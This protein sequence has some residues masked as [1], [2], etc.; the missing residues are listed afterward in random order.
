MN[1]LTVIVIAVFIVFIIIGYARGLLRSVFKLVLA[2]LALVLA[3]FLTPMVAKLI[4]DYTPIDNYINDKVYEGVENIAR[5]K[6]EKELIEEFGEVKDELV[7]SLTAAAL[8]L[9]PSRNQ[10]INIIQQLKLPQFMTDALIS[11]N[12][13]EVRAELDADGFYKYIA[14]YI[15]YM[16]MNA[17]SFLLTF[18]L[19]Q[20]LANIIYMALGV[21]SKLPIIGGID[22]M[23]GLLFGGL[24]ALLIVWVI[25]ILISTFANTEVGNNLYTQVNDSDFLTF[26]YKHNIFNDA[27][28]QISK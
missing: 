9:E 15:S 6:V 5:D 12:N 22:R 4:T 7:D 2:V 14:Y 24:E 3:Y 11:N 17:L 10:Q 20:I 18:T 21:V 13:D 8:E 16:V 23:A 25:L 28:T 27:I 26:L 19:I 1:I